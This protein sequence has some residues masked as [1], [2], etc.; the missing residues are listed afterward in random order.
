MLYRS[1]PNTLCFKAYYNLILRGFK[2]F[3]RPPVQRGISISNRQTGDRV[4]RPGIDIE[5][6]GGVVAADSQ[7][8]GTWTNDGYAVIE[9]VP[10]VI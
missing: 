1:E 2:P 6:A 3:F 5:H 7:V 10:K 9:G 4:C 8:R